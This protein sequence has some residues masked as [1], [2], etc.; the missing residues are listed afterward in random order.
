MFLALF[1]FL[2]K[3]IFWS[4]WSLFMEPVKKRTWRNM[5]LQNSLAEIYNKQQKT[6]EAPSDN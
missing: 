3:M 4:L 5:Y 6:K 1:I 2:N